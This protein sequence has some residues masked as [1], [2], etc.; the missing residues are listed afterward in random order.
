[1][2]SLLAQFGMVDEVTY[3][4]VV[5]PTR[6]YEFNSCDI[7]IQRGAVM[8]QGLRT[9]QRVQRS[10][11]FM[12][13]TMGASGTLT[14]DV[15]TKG[16]GLMLKHMLG[17]AAIGTISDSNYTQTFTIG[18]LLGDMFTAQAGKPLVG[19]ATVDPS[20]WH[21]CKVT[22]WE[23]ACDVD[24]LLVATIGIDAEDEDNS[25]ALATASYA[26][27]YRVF[28]FSDCAVTL[29][30]AGGGA[31]SFEV[32]SVSVTG[33]NNLDTERRFLTGSSLK[34]QPVENGFREYG[35]TM[36]A[37]WSS[38]TA[39]DLFVSS[40]AA[41]QLGE[42]VVTFEGPVAHA[43]STVPSL[44]ITLPAVRFA[45]VTNPISGPEKITSTITGEVLDNGSDQPITITYTT[46]D[47][48][49]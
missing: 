5:T 32:T 7:A 49:A 29:D 46:T 15:P 45:E 11:R 28:A 48:A 21:G 17:T 14:L 19:S 36:D 13:Y 9:G 27:D 44:V 37:E 30:P 33:N 35:I 22:E 41:G 24:G 18:T 20:T 31:A 8:S 3:G 12:P 43:G 6:F 1:M 38:T 25:T 39:Y 42:I 34:K 10:D 23:L 4:T 26:S 47:S 16:F 40:T 2:T